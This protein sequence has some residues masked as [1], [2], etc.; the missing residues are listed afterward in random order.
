MFDLVLR[1]GSVLTAEG[2]RVVD[3]GVANGRIEA[4]GTDLGE[5]ARTIRCDGAWVGPGFVDVHTHLRDP[6]QEWK[7]DIASGSAAAAAGGYTAVVAMP[8]TVPPIDSGDAARYVFDV[9][10]RSGITEVA[11]AGCLTLG[12]AGKRMAHIDDMWETGVRVFSDDGDALQDTNVL[13]IVMEKVARLGGVISKHAVDANLSAIGHMHEGQVSSDLGMSGIPREADNIIISR[14]IAF[15][16]MTGVRYHVQHLSTSESVDLIAQ[17]KADGVRITAEV[18]PH[19]LMFDHEDVRGSDTR[20]KMM[21]PLREPQDRTALVKGLRSGVIDVVA[22]DHAPHAATDKDGPFEEA[23][24]GVTGLE[25]AA[26]VA[27]SVVGLDQVDFFDRMSVA[28]ARIAGFDDQ[29][30]T[31]RLG[32]AA[33][34]VVFDPDAVWVPSST[35][36]K[37]QNAPYLGKQLQGRVKSTVF[38]G[39]V[40]HGA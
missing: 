23:A 35:V 18:T 2:V 9:G 1:N 13:R 25:W 4:I 17:A 8:N 19:H 31:L 5:T 15:A 24:N 29:G 14:D 26:A 11:S 3:V 36:S 16:K 38:R 30:Q 39:T 7:E 22:T 32:A 21:P 6:G 37:A 33:N 34:I 10:R 28:P 12:R 27:N 40:T 20:F